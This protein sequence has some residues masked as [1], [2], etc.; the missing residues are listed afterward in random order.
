[1]RKSVEDFNVERRSIIEALQG[2]GSLVCVAGITFV[3]EV[4]DTDELAPTIARLQKSFKTYARLLSEKIAEYENAARRSA[5]EVDRVLREQNE[6]KSGMSAKEEESR[7]TIVTLHSKLQDMVERLESHKEEAGQGRNEVDSMQ[8]Q[9]AASVAQCEE[10]RN[11]VH[12]EREEREL[13]EAK[14]TEAEN[15]ILSLS[16]KMKETGGM[17]EELESVKARIENSY[18]E[19]IQECEVLRA[20]IEEL[21]RKCSESEELLRMK[22][23]EGSSELQ[24]VRE[25]L[26]SY[27]TQVNSASTLLDRYMYDTDNFEDGTEKKRTITAAIALALTEL[28]TTK[29]NLEDSKRQVISVQNEMARCVSK[30]ETSMNEMFQKGQK[31]ASESYQVMIAEMKEELEQ[32]REEINICKEAE[33]DAKQRIELLKEE[34]NRIAV[35]FNER[36]RELD[37]AEERESCLAEQI[38]ALEDDLAQKVEVN[39]KEVEGRIGIMEKKLEQ[40]KREAE[41]HRVAELNLRKVI[42]EFQ[43]AK[44]EEIERRIEGLKMQLEE[45]KK[46]EGNLEVLKKEKS[47]IED[48]LQGRDKDLIRLKAELGRAQEE[49]IEKEI[50]IDQERSETKNEE[51]VDRRIIRQMLVRFLGENSGRR[52]EVLELM[53]KMLDFGEEDL[54]MAGLKRKKFMERLGDMVQTSPRV[55]GDVTLGPVGSVS[56]KW[57]EFL[58]KETEPEEENF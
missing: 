2:F 24:A 45:A 28:S 16:E 11:A 36:T 41:S 19:S 1:M 40:V 26:D 53:T 42:E 8:K 20:R 30:H 48:S 39:E 44:E 10:L 58:M 23:S 49:K 31:E 37:E 32:L 6:M 25:A 34:K 29:D 3:F 14:V 15:E 47:E 18:N 22:E 57:I 27:C 9:L 4:N 43:E 56:D 54:V 51:M 38:S 46:L 33:N 52:R 55:P 35:Q 12:Q 21:E 7:A 5:K 17:T 50:E 13:S